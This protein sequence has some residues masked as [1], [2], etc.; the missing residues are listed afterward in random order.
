MSKMLEITLTEV[1]T[2]LW[3]PIQADA[4]MQS[5]I[6]WVNEKV[7]S[8]VWDLDLW[9]KVMEVQY[10][11]VK[12]STFTLDI[13]N[14]TDL[15][16]INWTDV[17]GLSAWSDYLIKSDWNVIINNL[18]DYLAT[19]NVTNFWIF[20]VKYNAGY[21]IAPKTLIAT[22]SNYAW[23]LYSQDTWKDVIA[24]QLWPRWVDYE[25]NTSEWENIALKAFKTGIRRFIPLALKI[26]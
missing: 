21:A 22:V 14:A 4:R 15:T 3:Q 1:Q 23:Y 7:E 24:E 26:Y 12:N 19:D 6:D 11:T 17:S 9:E 25:A 13:I 20:E 18:C 5:I 16:D 8:N 2:Y 10:N